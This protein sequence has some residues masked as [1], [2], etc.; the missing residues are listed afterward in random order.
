MIPDSDD[1]KQ[2]PMQALMLL[3]ISPLLSEPELMYLLR[4]RMGNPA[5]APLSV[6]ML[7]RSDVS[8]AGI[9]IAH[10]SSFNAALEAK[11]S[12]NIPDSTLARFIGS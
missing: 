5:P 2:Q 1:D 10:Y 7:Y 12:L 9:G 6:Q 8:N 11:R 4:E 3:G